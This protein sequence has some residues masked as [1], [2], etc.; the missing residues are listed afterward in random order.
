MEPQRYHRIL[1]T[2][3]T[4]FIGRH[5]VRK[6]LSQGLSLRLF[7]RSLSKATPLFGEKVD[8]SLG[9]LED[10][11]AIERAMNGCDAVIHLGGLYRF[12]RRYEKELFETNVRGTENLLNA[13]IQYSI[14]RFLFIGTAGVLKSNLPLLFENDFPKS[15]PWGTPYKRSKWEAES[16]VLQ[17]IQNGFPAL[18]ASPTCPIGDE[19]DSP[20]PTG[21]MIVDFLNHDFPFYTHSG[22]NVIDIEDLIAG[23]LA[24]FFRGQIGQRYLLAGENLW[25]R[26][27]LTILSQ[28]TGIPAPHYAISS[29]LL[30][31][32]ALLAEL[33]SLFGKKTTR[34]NL[35][36]ALHAGR[37]QFYDAQKTYLDL[38]WRPSFDTKKAVE[39]AIRSIQ[40]RK[41]LPQLLS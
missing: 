10:P 31:A 37:I 35:E 22:I 21:K 39:K 29:P 15:A 33:S 41:Q 11:Q 6:M 13:S 2:G 38:D 18:I 3:A 9:S 8:Y 14:K 36:T 16:K 32:G 40:S 28:L 5:L 34:L 20:T 19:D 25:L 7:V 27:F 17:A 1:I 24:T 23:I 12:G 26:E 4:G 30:F